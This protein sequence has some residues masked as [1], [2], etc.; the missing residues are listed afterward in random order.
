MFHAALSRYC[1]GLA[2]CDEVLRRNRLIQINVIAPKSLYSC[3]QTRSRGQIQRR[4]WLEV[5]E[6]LT[7]ASRDYH[8]VVAALVVY[9]LGRGVVVARRTKGNRPHMNLSSVDATPRSG[10]VR[11]RSLATL[12]RTLT[13][14]RK[15]PPSLAKYHHCRMDHCAIDRSMVWT[16]PRQRLKPRTGRLHGVAPPTATA[17]PLQS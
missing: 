1:D 9:F 8:N 12:N 10:S 15:A 2:N 6:D 14:V 11:W 13:I 4:T 17:C 5:S 7:Q 16:C 3:Q